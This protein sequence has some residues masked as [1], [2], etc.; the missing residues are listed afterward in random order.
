MSMCFCYLSTPSPSKFYD[1]PEIKSKRSAGFGYGNKM[2]LAKQNTKT[3]GPNIYKLHSSFD[4][5][6]QQGIT[7]GEGRDRI[8][9]GDMFQ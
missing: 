5:K 9:A 8:K 3:P 4:M 1:L 2:D 6:S 7:M